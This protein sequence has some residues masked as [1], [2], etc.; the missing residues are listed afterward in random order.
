[1]K[2]IF[3]A[4]TL[5]S[6][7]LQAQNYLSS[8]DILSG[9]SN[10]RNLKNFRVCSNSMSPQIPTGS[11]VEVDRNISLNEIYPGDIIVYRTMLPN[12]YN[13][14]HVIHRV[15]A[16]QGRYLICKGDQNNLVDPE[17]VNEIN[18]VGVV[19]GINRA[20]FYSMR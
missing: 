16:H 14:R 8:A 15:V 5:I 12:K 2:R 18:L 19:T 4:L 17:L 7:S 13:S 9:F 3:I 1:M 6:C 11:L 20:N 10:T